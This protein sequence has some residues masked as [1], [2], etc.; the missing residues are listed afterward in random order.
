M[1]KLD[2]SKIYFTPSKMTKEERSIAAKK[3]RTASKLKNKRT[4]AIIICCVLAVAAIPTIT[5]LYHK[6]RFDTTFEA[7]GLPDYSKTRQSSI[8]GGPI[9][10][11]VEGREAGSLN[12]IKATLKYLAY[13]DITGVVASVHDYFGF[14]FFDTYV[15]RDVCLA[16]G[17]LQNSLS[18]PDISYRQYDRK[19]YL[20]FQNFEVDDINKYYYGAFR[21]KYSDFNMSNNHLIPATKEVRDQILGLRR[22]ETVRLVGYLVSMYSDRPGEPVYTSSLRRDDGGNGACEIMFVTKL[23]KK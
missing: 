4:V 16:W 12:G 15:P 22:G 6:Y 23:E 18:D 2:P 20:S 10:I 7:L 8:N 14:G 1:A 11:D 5:I 19:C 17:D 13:Y 9:Q 3:Y 21:N